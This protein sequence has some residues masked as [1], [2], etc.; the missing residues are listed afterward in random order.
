MSSDP[1]TSSGQGGTPHEM[2]KRIRE[3][4]DVFDSAGEHIGTVGDL[5]IGDPDA[6]DVHGPGRLPGEGLARARGPPPEPNVPAGLVGRLLRTGYIKID[7]KRHARRD[8]HFYATADQ[9]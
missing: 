2:M 3:G 1:T 5:R 8:H 9:I 4:M 6:I 7:D